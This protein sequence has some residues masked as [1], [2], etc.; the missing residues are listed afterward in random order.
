MVPAYHALR[1]HR[2]Q[3][4]VAAGQANWFATTVE[5]L[6]P[7]CL[8]EP[9][10]VF[11]QAVRSGPSGD[12]A[13]ASGSLRYPSGDAEARLVVWDPTLR[14]AV[15]AGAGSSSMSEERGTRPLRVPTVA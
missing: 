10:V 7:G 15:T 1:L 3:W 13:E 12:G 11:E 2:R 9:Q 14:A 4:L 6:A 5:D 8:S